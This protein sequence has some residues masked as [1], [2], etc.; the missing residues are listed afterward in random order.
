MAENLIDFETTGILHEA[1]EDGFIDVI[2]EFIDSGK[3]IT[4]QLL[5]I[6]EK[7]DFD[8]DKEKVRLLAHSLK[9]ASG[10]IGAHLLSIKCQD[11]ESNVH[12]LVAENITE[13][14]NEI[15]DIFMK[16]QDEYIRQF[17]MAT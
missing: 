7:S 8:N 1:L 15:K 5:Q 6:I 9:G 14:V 11:L 4:G 17:K 2:N 16:T 10:N 3:E 13:L 12:T